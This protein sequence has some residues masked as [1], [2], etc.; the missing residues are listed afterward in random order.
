MAILMK[1]GTL[2]YIWNVGHG[3]SD[4][5]GDMAIMRETVAWLYC[6]KYGTCLF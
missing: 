1:V 4:I 6:G 2:L 5:K 3:Y